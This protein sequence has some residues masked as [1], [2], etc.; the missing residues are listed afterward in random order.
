[1]LIVLTLAKHNVAAIQPAGN[2]SGDEK[3]RAV[4]VSALWCTH[5]KQERGQ[6]YG[7]TQPECAFWCLCMPLAILDRPTHATQALFNTEYTAH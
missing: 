6:G 1:M 2:D 5:V 3:L 7:W 4:G